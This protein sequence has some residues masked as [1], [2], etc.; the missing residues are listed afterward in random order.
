M[1]VKGEKY[2]HDIFFWVTSMINNEMKHENNCFKI[3]ATHFV[4]P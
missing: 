4:P 3:L 2:K 1:K